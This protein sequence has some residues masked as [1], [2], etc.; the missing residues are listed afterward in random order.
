MTLT[1]SIM[2]KENKEVAGIYEEPFRK[3]RKISTE[4]MQ[5]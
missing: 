4:R 5:K 2:V 1:P 3:L